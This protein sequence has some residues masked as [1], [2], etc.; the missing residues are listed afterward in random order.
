MSRVKRAPFLV[1]AAVV[2]GAVS[3]TVQLAVASTPFAA[4]S[5]AL[6][7]SGLLLFSVV[8]AAGLLLSRGRWALRLAVAVIAVHLGLVVVIELTAWTM[9]SMAANLLA[10]VGLTGPWLRGWL[11]QRPAAGGPP[12]R[13]VLLLLGSLALLPG[14]A[15]A[16]PEELG[17]QHGALAAAAVVSSWGYS[18]A[19][20]WGLW[21]LR[22]AVLPLAVLA[23]P[24]SPIGGAVYLLFHAAAVTG[25]AWTPE[26]AR[27][28]RPLLDRVYGPRSAR[29]LESRPEDAS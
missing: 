7:A 15:V 18:R 10:L 13:A 24:A 12:D 16:S 6:L 17:W 26:A 27:A 25:L 3:L 4:A 8:T 14:T 28:V 19:A 1:S 20:A 29:P 22:V 11:R 9:V 2:L 23:A 5:A 21:A